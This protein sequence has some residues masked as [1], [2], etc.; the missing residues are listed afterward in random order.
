[1][2]FFRR[3]SNNNVSNTNCNGIA[4]ASG[5]NKGQRAKEK[6]SPCYTTS[7]PSCSCARVDMNCEVGCSA[8]GG[9][10]LPARAS[11]LSKHRSVGDDDHTFPVDF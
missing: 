5:E 10:A 2:G 9:P 6:I 11:A 1:M 3:G 8:G 7:M 4:A